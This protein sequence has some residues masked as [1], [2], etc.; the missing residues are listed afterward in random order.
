MSPAFYCVEADPLLHSIQAAMRR[1]DPES[2]VLACMDD[3][4]FVGTAEAVWAG[5]EVYKTG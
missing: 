5:Q 2:R 3:T 4:Q 1:H